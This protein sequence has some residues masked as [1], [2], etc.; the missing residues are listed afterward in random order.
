MVLSM[1]YSADYIHSSMYCQSPPSGSCIIARGVYFQW[2]DIF[3]AMKYFFRNYLLLALEVY[4]RLS[5]DSIGFVA[6][7]SK[8]VYWGSIS[9]IYSLW[10][11]FLQWPF[12]FRRHVGC[13][14]YI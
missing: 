11:S 10:T 7:Q 3:F 5:I 14:E 4:K 12:G 8:I 13:S 2:R 1:K 6:I 9:L